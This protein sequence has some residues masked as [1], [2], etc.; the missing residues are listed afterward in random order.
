MHIRK[1]SEQ[2]TKKIIDFNLYCTSFIPLLYLD[3]GRGWNLSFYRDAEGKLHILHPYAHPY[4][5][6]WIVVLYPLYQVLYDAIEDVK[7]LGGCC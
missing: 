7:P 6:N 4:C 2:F 1:R 5:T 3:M